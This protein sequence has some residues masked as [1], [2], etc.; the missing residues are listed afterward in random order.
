MQAIHW[1]VIYS[2]ETIIH[3]GLALIHDLQQVL[4]HVCKIIIYTLL[5]YLLLFPVDGPADTWRF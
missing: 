3:Q 2:V 4:K 1:I 5:K